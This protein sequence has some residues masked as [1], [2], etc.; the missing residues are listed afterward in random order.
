MSVRF[1]RIKIRVIAGQSA[2]EKLYI[3]L[4]F[5][6][7]L[8]KP[9]PVTPASIFFSFMWWS[10]KDNVPSDFSILNGV[11]VGNAAPGFYARAVVNPNKR[12]NYTRFQAFPPNCLEIVID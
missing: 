4:P 7:S 10:M 3:F 6:E 8:N 9:V 2:I 11:T 1:I 5:F 12:P